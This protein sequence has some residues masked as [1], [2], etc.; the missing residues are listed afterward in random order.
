[1]EGKVAD[2]REFPETVQVR[3]DTFGLTEKTIPDMSCRMRQA[4]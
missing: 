2:E 1:M 4:M 3:K